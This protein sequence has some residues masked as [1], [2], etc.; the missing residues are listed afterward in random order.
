M[1]LVRTE[2]FGISTNLND[3]TSYGLI[4]PFG[5]F[6][7]SGF[8]S[9]RNDTLSPF[10]DNY[11]NVAN[12]TGATF[13]LPGNY[14]SFF[15]GFRVYISIP[16]VT[17]SDQPV[18]VFMDIDSKAQFMISLNVDNGII[19]VWAGRS[20]HQPYTGGTLL[21]AS[22]PFVFPGNAWFYFEVGATIGTSGSVTIRVN[23][24]PVMTLTGVDTNGVASSVTTLNRIAVFSY[25]NSNNVGQFPRANISLAHH[26]VCDDS[27]PA[28]QNTFLGDIR[29]QTLLPNAAGDLTQFTPVGGAANWQNVATVPPNPNVDYNTAATVGSTDLFNTPS[30]SSLDTYILGVQVK[31]LCSKSDAG[32]R[33]VAPMIKSGTTTAQGTVVAPSTNPRYM[34]STYSTDPDTGLQWTQAAVDA[35]QIGYTI[36]T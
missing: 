4:L 7:I 33:T 11:F 19:S 6:G 32:P 3:F 15:A 1:A 21:G 29:V 36:V 24:I 25:S 28:P 13:L 35:V 8:S 14:T 17:G 23:S 5:D 20:D 16:N 22:A 31:T 30:M 12:L 27:G 9:I 10:G 18:F 26:Y 34:V 2:G